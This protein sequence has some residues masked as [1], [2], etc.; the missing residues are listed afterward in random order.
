MVR[1]SL[2]LPKSC[3]SFFQISQSFFGDSYNIRKILGFL[4]EVYRERR[5]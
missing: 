1:E 4:R 3:K 2:D 5:Y